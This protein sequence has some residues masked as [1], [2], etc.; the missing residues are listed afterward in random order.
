MIVDGLKTKYFRNLIKGLT[1]HSVLGRHNLYQFFDNIENDF[2]AKTPVL[3]A[4]GLDCKN[5]F[6]DKNIN[7]DIKLVTTHLFILNEKHIGKKYK[8]DYFNVVSKEEGTKEILEDLKIYFAKDYYAHISISDFLYEIF[9]N[10][11]YL[12]KN[13]AESITNCFQQ[14]FI[15]RK[16]FITYNNFSVDS[17]QLFKYPELLSNK[18]VFLKTMSYKLKHKPL[19]KIDDLFKQYENTRQKYLRVLMDFNAFVNRV[20]S[21]KERNK[22]I[23][24][25]KQVNDKPKWVQDVFKKSLNLNNLPM[26]ATDSE[27]VE[28]KFNKKG[29][30]TGRIKTSKP[31]IEEK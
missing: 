19:N 3:A 21:N 14:S 10:R 4:D 28:F 11:I 7:H 27:E 24:A 30:V 25:L 6:H 2:S 26:Q 18:V 23:N 16:Y 29:T 8:L 9:G 5:P 12:R 22:Q 1:E 20:H 15:K 31:N 13:Y 17:F